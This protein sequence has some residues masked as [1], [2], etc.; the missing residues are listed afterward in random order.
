M[1]KEQLAKIVADK[2]DAAL[3]ASDH[4]KKF[5]IT[6]NGRGVTDGGDLYNA[7]LKDVLGVVS[8]ALVDIFQELAAASARSAEKQAAKPVEKPAAAKPADKL[9]KGKR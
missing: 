1:D 5:F 8:V 6:A 2:I 3:Q 9:S 4:P 7:L